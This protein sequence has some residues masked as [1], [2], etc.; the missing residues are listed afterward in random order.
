MEHLRTDA[1]FSISDGNPIWYEVA[2]YTSSVTRPTPLVATQLCR[3]IF[4][5]LSNDVADDN[6]T[7]VEH[8]GLSTPT[9]IHSRRKALPSAARYHRIAPIRLWSARDGSVNGTHRHVTRLYRKYR[10]S[11]CHL[12]YLEGGDDQEWRKTCCATGPVI[13]RFWRRI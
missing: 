13:R 12:F 4:H 1:S 5:P 2:A 8:G 7:G 10:I 9:L 6:S 11:A 3:N